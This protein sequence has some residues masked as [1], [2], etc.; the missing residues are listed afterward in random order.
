MRGPRTGRAA[1]GRAAVVFALVVAATAGEAQGQVN[2]PQPPPP[3]GPTPRAGSWE[4]TGGY[5]FVGGYDLDSANA[6]LTRNTTTGDTTFVQFITDSSVQSANAVSPLI[7]YYF[8]S[9]L[10]V[11]GGLRYGKPI[12][13]IELSDDAE[14][15]LDEVAEDTIDQYVFTGSL[16]YH[17][18]RARS[19]VVPFVKGGMGYLRELHEGQELVETGTEYHA[20][21]G[22]K[23]WFGTARRR[24]GLRGEGGM[25]FRDGGF[26]F[27]DSLRMTPTAGISLVYLF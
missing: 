9:R 2:R 11:E 6:E 4:I 21:A 13:R 24:L 5:T 7:S 20:G 14:G 27:E 1:F 25:S 18:P 16:V 12:Y 22:V 17:F 15:A 3:S 8:S 10:A 23:I 26:D 19:S